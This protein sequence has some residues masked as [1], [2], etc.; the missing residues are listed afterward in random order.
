MRENLTIAHNGG[1]NPTNPHQEIL[2]DLPIIISYALNAD[3]VIMLKIFI[4]KDQS[5]SS[6]GNLATYSMNV[7]NKRHI[8]IQLQLRQDLLQQE[9][10]TP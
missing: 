2:V 4:L 1:P 5:V 9:E 3:K 10:S 6:V 7:D 8:S